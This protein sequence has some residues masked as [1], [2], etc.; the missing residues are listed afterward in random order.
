M[1]THVIFDLDHT[2]L[3]TRSFDRAIGDV[4][5]RF[6]LSYE[7]YKEA[8]AA[9]VSRV[10]GTYDFSVPAFL[11]ILA[12]RHPKLSGHRAGIAE[13]MER[14]LDG[15]MAHLFPGIGELLEALRP[16]V[17]ELTLLTK[18]N[19]E[20]QAA[21][22]ERSGVA[23]VF[24]RHV[25]VE[26]SKADEL[27]GLISRD[28]R[29]VFVNDNPEENMEIRRRFPE[30][31]LLHVHGPLGTPEDLVDARVEGVEGVSGALSDILDIP[32]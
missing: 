27:E 24:D 30:L 5:A 2:I 29:T 28:H 14:A 21:K 19:R 15:V 23:Q 31:I 18:G 8:Y 20:W 26:G 13:G 10:P 7:Q 17:D 12:A 1:K 4:L 11:D 9:T 32:L 25:Y 16:H 3:D 6:G 22:V